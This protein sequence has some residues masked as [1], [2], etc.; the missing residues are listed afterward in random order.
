[1]LSAVPMAIPSQDGDPTDHS[2]A[3]TSSTTGA[4][5]ELP[6]SLEKT[7]NISG[8]MDTTTSSGTTYQP[9]TVNSLS[10]DEGAGAPAVHNKGAST[11]MLSFTQR[12]LLTH[13][14]ITQR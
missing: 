1:M 4:V 13:L 9:P 6:Q 12:F 11:V 7:E 5:A 2:L 3:S 10:S 14:K 8:T